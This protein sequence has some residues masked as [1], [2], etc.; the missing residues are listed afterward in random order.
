VEHLLL[1][2]NQ[3]GRGLFTTRMGNAPQPP[4]LSR[5]GAPLLRWRGLSLNPRRCAG[6][7]PRQVY[8]PTWREDALRGAVLGMLISLG[9]VLLLGGVAYWL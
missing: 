1:R 6:T 4:P 5:L 3:W 2:G 7:N 8:M 9:V